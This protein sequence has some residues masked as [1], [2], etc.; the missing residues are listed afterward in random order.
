MNFFDMIKNIDRR[1]IFLF[2]A[3]S[4]GIPLLLDLSFTEYPSE[5]TKQIYNKIEKLPAG[6][7]VLFSFDYDPPSEP[8]LQPMA[9]SFVRHC[10]K[11]GHKIYFMALWPMGQTLAK[12]VINEVIVKEFPHY[13]YGVDYIHLGYKAG[14]QMVINVILSN[15]YQLYSLDVE[16]KELLKNFPIMANVKNLKSID[17]IVNISAGEPGIKEWVQ[18]GGDPTGVPIVGGLTA[19]QAPLMYPYYPIQLLGLLG[20]IKGAAEYE[21]MLMKNFPEYKDRAKHT[22]VK[23]MGPQTVA[24]AI[25]ILFIIIGNIT[26]YIEWRRGKNKRS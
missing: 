11:R 24:H 5:M 8:E 21:A 13:R 12:N 1:I 17:L 14:N 23:R 22:A 4:V 10:A 15:F 9:V 26:F 16:R 6:S 18:Y 25:I 19:V 3:L 20:G 2:V 7:K